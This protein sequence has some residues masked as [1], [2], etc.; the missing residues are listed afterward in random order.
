MFCR[1]DGIRI[2]GL[3]HPV[4]KR[5]YISEM[6]YFKSYDIGAHKITL[7]SGGSKATGVTTML[8]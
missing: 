8:L 5:G 2:Q 4:Y 3:N 6:F 7:Q 1:T